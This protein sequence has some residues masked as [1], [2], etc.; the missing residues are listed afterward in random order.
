[1]SQVFADWNAGELDSYLIEITRDILGVT[2]PRDGEHVVD[3]ILD[4]AGQKGTGKWTVNAA[5]DQGMPLTLIAEAVFAR[6]LSAAKDERVRPQR[7]SYGPT[8]CPST[9]DVDAFVEDLR[10]ALYASKIV[11]Y[12]Q[13]YQLM[14]AAASARGWELNFGGI[15]LIWRGGCIIRSVFLGDIKKAF[16]GNPQ[17]A[18]LLL[19]PFFKAGG[20]TPPG[21]MAARRRDGGHRWAFL[22]LV[23]A[24]ARVLRRLP[25][26][27]AAGKPAAG[28]A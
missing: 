2:R 17:L 1:M 8:S 4:T 28:A 12:A 23:S 27:P 18:N 6:C 15:A 10:Q 11:S 9:G 22:C 19:D 5:L 16:D 14:R 20:R 25:V 3:M 13:G 26:G 7:S 21:G 24:R